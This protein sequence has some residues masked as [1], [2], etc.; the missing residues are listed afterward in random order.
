[1]EQSRTDQCSSSRS[2]TTTSTNI[3]EESLD[4]SQRVDNNPISSFEDEDQ[5]EYNKLSITSSLNSLTST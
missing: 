5:D 4:E 3:D 2:K 1:M